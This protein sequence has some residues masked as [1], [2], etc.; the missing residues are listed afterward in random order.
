MRPLF[1]RKLFRPRH[2]IRGCYIYFPINQLTLSL[3]GCR[4][5][6]FVANHHKSFDPPFTKFD[7]I[8]LPFEP[9]KLNQSSRLM[10]MTRM[11]ETTQRLISRPIA[12]SASSGA[13]PSENDISPSE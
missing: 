12:T 6:G 10:P 7:F 1:G 5:I 3:L 11:L 4:G 2:E 13:V 8:D 9:H